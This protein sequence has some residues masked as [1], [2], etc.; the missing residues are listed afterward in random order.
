MCLFMSQEGRFGQGPRESCSVLC[1]A[2]HW[3][4][5]QTTFWG[6][7]T[8]LSPL[9]SE[10]PSRWGGCE[11]RAGRE[12]GRRGAFLLLGR[13]PGPYC[14]LHNPGPAFPSTGSSR[15]STG[16]QQR[17]LPSCSYPSTLQCHRA[18]VLRAECGPAFSPPAALGVPATCLH[19]AVALSNVLRDT[20]FV[21][22]LQKDGPVVVHI[23][24]GDE[25]GGCACAPLA[26]WAVVCGM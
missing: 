3:L 4:S 24:D 14:W 10:R 12:R 11:E 2:G 1:L 6:N 19:N 20:G 16:L 8:S 21:A 17:E 5:P 18:R 25:Y 26:Y 13:Q 23:Q 7:V 9:C 15:S 22:A